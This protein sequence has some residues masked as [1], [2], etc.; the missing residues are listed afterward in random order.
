MRKILI[1][2]LGLVLGLPASAKAPKESVE[3]LTARV[4]RTAAVQYVAIDAELPE[5]RFPV[6]IKKGALSHAEATSWVA[7][8]YPGSLWYIYLYGKDERIRTLAEKYTAAM[9]PATRKHISHDLGFQFNCSYGNALRITGDEKWQPTL[10]EAARLLAARFNPVAGV[11][12]SWNFSPKDK[13]WKFPVIIDNMMNLELLMEACRLTGADSLKNI[14]VTHAKTTMKNHFRPDGTCY[15]VLDYD[16]ETGEVRWKGTHQGYADES[17]WA[18]GQGWA[19]YGFTMMYEKTGEEAFLRQAETVARMLLKRLPADG[20]PYWDFDAP[21]IPDE[22]RD[23]SAAAIMSSAFVRLAGFTPDG[24]LAK[25][26]LKMSETQIRTLASPLYLAPVGENCGFLL[27]HSVGNL[28]KK[29]QVD[30]PLSY[31]DYYFLEALLR[32]NKIL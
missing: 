4:F 11:T 28:P 18:R 8:F 32:W 26:C 3:D 17:A 13:D 9:E 24:K 21:E 10:L 7:G 14:A 25:Q 31:A 19:L 22:H 5:G 29:S 23:A 16:P 30:V 27:R 6:S 12:R 20:I 15:H 2:A 1:I